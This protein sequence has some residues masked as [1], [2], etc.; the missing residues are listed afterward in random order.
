MVR[1]LMLYADRQDVLPY[2]VSQLLSAWRGRHG[3]RKRERDGAC[4]TLV[5]I[6]ST[7][8]SRNADAAW[9]RGHNPDAR[10]GLL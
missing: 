8:I 5:R 6:Y 3:R 10:S 7:A 2:L 4:T 1:R 9:S